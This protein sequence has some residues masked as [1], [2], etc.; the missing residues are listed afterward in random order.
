MP[1]PPWASR[2]DF[3]HEFSGFCG[4][5]PLLSGSLGHPFGSL[6][7]QMLSIRPSMTSQS[8]FWKAFWWIFPEDA[9]LEGP[10]E[11]VARGRYVIRT[12]R[13]SPNAVFE[14]HTLT[15]KG[16]IF[17]SLWEAFG[18]HWGSF[19]RLERFRRTFFDIIWFLT[20]FF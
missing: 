15:P 9:F 4:H 19:C 6:G 5:L 3:F 11:L 8:R 16:S 10:G 20:R 18:R 17:E 2:G 13:R 7:S 12:H 1:V 14:K